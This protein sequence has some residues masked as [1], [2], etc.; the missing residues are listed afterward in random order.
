MARVAVSQLA[1]LGRAEEYLHSSMDADKN[2]EAMTMLGDLMADTS[3]GS[4]E[5][6]ALLGE[7]AAM[8]PPWFKQRVALGKTALGREDRYAGCLLSPA[9][10]V[11]S[12]SD[13]L[14]SHTRDMRREYERPPLLVPDASHLNELWT[15]G[16]GGLRQIVAEVDGVHGVG[17]GGLG[18]L[19]DDV[20]DVSVHSNNGRTFAQFA[21]HRGLDGC[22]LHRILEHERPVLIV[23][24]EDGTPQL[25]ISGL[26]VAVE[27]SRDAEVLSG[28]V[29]FAA[30]ETFAR[31]LL[32]AYEV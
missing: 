2:V 30:S 19:G 22:T 15:E 20:T 5:H 24:R 14:R 1:D 32:G 12:S 17:R 13:Q 10:M 9:L 6:R 8:G 18:T 21:S 25:K 26:Q 4:A 23:S 31:L 29:R 16:M 7:L 28:L 27:R 3:P 11:R